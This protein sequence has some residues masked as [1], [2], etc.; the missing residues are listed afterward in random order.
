MGMMNRSRLLTCA[1]LV[2]GL[3]SCSDSGTP[4]SPTPSEGVEVA[5]T[6]DRPVLDLS[7]PLFDNIAEECANLS[8]EYRALRNSGSDDI[9]TRPDAIHWETDVYAAVKRATEEQKPIFLVSC[10]NKGGKLKEAAC[11]T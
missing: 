1:A 5:S 3:G 2:A 7:K 8:N 6:N 9:T 11:D 4:N 10:V